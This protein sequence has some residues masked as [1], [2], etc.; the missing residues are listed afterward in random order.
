LTICRYAGYRF[1]PEIVH[2]AIWLYFQFTIK[3]LCWSEDHLARRSNSSL[4]IETRA[5]RIPRS[6]A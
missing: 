2:Q 3:P 6:T 1:A 4:K 5:F